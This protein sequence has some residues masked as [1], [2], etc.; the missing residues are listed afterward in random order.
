MASQ[1]ALY[2][3]VLCKY[4]YLHTYIH[5]SYVHLQDGTAVVL[6]LGEVVGEPV[7]GFAEGARVFLSLGLKV[8][9]R[10]D[11]LR[12]VGL[13]LCGTYEVDGFTEGPY[14]SQKTQLLVSVI[15]IKIQK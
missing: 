6:L 1:S 2:T 12:V 11:G 15:K 8:G 5:T 4:S 13:K 3:A 7:V 10:E 9:P 14:I